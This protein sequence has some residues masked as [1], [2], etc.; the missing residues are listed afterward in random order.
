ML[1]TTKKAKIGTLNTFIK[2]I[3]HNPLGYDKDEMIE[4]YYKILLDATERGLSTYCGFYENKWLLMID[5]EV[6]ER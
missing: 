6:Y 4:M 1:Y 3:R 2:C 5:N